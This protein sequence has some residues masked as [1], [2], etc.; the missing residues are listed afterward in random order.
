MVVK[1]WS[2]GGQ[3]VVK[4]WS[5]GGQMVVKWWSNGGQ[6]VVKWCLIQVRSTIKAQYP[7]GLYYILYTAVINE[8]LK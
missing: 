5:N 8:L 2:N 3:M 1:W 6:M 7:T 4:W